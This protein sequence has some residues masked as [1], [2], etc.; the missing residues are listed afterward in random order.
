[1][2]AAVIF[3]GTLTGNTQTVAEK[4]AELCRAQG[5]EVET[6]NIAGLDAA[7]LSTEAATVILASSTWDDGHLQADWQDF[8]D[9][10]A[11]ETISLAGK[12]VAIFGCG[13]SNYTHFCSAVDLLE[14]YA[15]Q[16]GG[17]KII[18]S[19]KVDGFPD[20]ENNQQQIQAWAT[21]LATL[22]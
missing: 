1:M 8:I 12:K 14:Q 15:T 16:K 21:Q 13:D 20:M 4:I 10:T 22:I 2:A 3:Y 17:Q 6:K 9:R 5:K 18:D 11:N 7:D 19:L